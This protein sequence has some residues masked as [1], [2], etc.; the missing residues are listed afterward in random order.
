[1]NTGKGTKHPRDLDQVLINLLYEGPDIE[2]GA[3]SL[4]DV[5]PILQGFSG[6][7][8]T[9]VNK[10]YPKTSHQIYISDIRPGSVDIVLE[11]WQWVTEN[12]DTLTTA[13]APILAQP[14]MVFSIMSTIFELSKLKIHISNEAYTEQVGDGQNIA[15]NNAENVTLNFHHE[16]YQIYKDGDLDGNM[17]NLVQPL[18][19]GRINSAEF[20]VTSQDG[21]TISQTIK[22]RGPPQ[23]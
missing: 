19:P 1:M 20:K 14:D 2:N 21:K 7:Y 5:I 16:T 15:I 9:L 12:T 22:A 18:E 3:M 10:K 11:A 6:A 17:R 13:A 8:A 4:Q 23:L